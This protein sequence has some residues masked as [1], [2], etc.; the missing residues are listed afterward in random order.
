M[1][2]GT[3]KMWDSAKNFG[4]IEGDDDVDYFVQ[5]S[6]IEPTV[7]GRKLK[8]GQRVGFDAKTEMRG[9]RAIRVRLANR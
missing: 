6:D 3:V 2:Y 8:A 1:I 4:F 7:P 5:P 9:D